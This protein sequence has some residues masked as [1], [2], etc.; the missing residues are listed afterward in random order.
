MRPLLYIEPSLCHT[1]PS[2]SARRACKPRAILQIE[3]GDLPAVD[4][5]RCLGCKACVVAC[6]H[7]AV[8]SL[9]ERPAFLEQSQ[10]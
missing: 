9:Y 8:M 7:G 10:P 3:R 5:E 2:C 6:P 4:A 1:C